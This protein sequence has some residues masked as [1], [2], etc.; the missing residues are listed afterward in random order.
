MHICLVVK[1]QLGALLRTEGSDVQDSGDQI[2]K[3]WSMVCRHLSVEG[4]QTPSVTWISRHHAQCHL[5]GLALSTVNPST[6]TPSPFFE[7]PSFSRW[8]LGLALGCKDGNGALSL[9]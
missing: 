6:K 9:Q 7:R 3:L 8:C 4:F 2:G 1:R 5:L